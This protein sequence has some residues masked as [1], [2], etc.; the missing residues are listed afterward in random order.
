MQKKKIP[1][2]YIVDYHDDIVVQTTDD[3]DVIYKYWRDI[4]NEEM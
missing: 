1:M 3:N 2:L 4:W